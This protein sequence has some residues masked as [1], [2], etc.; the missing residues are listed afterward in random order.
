MTGLR[1]DYDGFSVRLPDGWNDVLEEG[2]YSDPEEPPPATFATKTGP[3][4]MYV[5]APVYDEDDALHPAHG[6]ERLVREWGRRRGGREPIGVDIA[7][8]PGG[9]LGTATYRVADDFVQ[10]WCLV[11]AGGVVQASYVCPW[12]RRHEERDAREDLAASLRFA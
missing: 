5:T 1:V 6:A 12:A 8:A 11:G 7:S 9:A 4:T 3:G 2:T 10:I